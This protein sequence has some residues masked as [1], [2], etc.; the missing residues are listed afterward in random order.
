V[1]A[2]PSRR[3]CPWGEVGRV[4]AVDLVLV[5]ADVVAAELLEV[6]QIKDEDAAD[7]RGRGVLGD[8]GVETVL[9]LDT[10]DVAAGRALADDDRAR[11]AHV[12]AR[13]GGAD[14]LALL[15]EHVLAL[16]RVDPVGPAGGGV[17]RGELDAELAEGHVLAAGHLHA[18]PLG[19]AHVEV[20]DGEARDLLHA[21]PLGPGELAL[22]IKDGLVH[23]LAPEGHA[24]GRDAQRVGEAERARVED[25]RGARDRADDGLGDDLLGRARRERHAGGRH[26]VAER[27][28][29]P[30]AAAPPRRH[31]TGS[32]RR[33]PPPRR[34]GGPGQR[35]ARASAGDEGTSGQDSP[36]ASPPRQPKATTRD[37]HPAVPGG[38]CAALPRGRQGASTGR[39]ADRVVPEGQ[40]HSEEN[41][42]GPA[43]RAARVLSAGRGPVR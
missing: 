24:G 19:V 38:R 33:R 29:G 4:V 40:T 2:G 1:P 20:L 18:V 43:K 30:G 9:D 16:D 21:D 14:G 35:G 7:V 39:A 34:Q 27:R 12:D 31:S 23:A 25:E 11:L 32:R 10:G 28:G 5:D 3:C 15:D 36:D 26:A 6:R 8:V 41:G 37:L 22:E 17:R 13:V 42:A